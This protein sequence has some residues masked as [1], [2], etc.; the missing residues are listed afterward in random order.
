MLQPYCTPKHDVR[1][2]IYPKKQYVYKWHEQP[3][4]DIYMEDHHQPLA[5]P[6]LPLTGLMQLAATRPALPTTTC[7]PQAL[8]MQWIYM[9]GVHDKTQG[10]CKAKPTGCQEEKGLPYPAY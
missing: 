10:T 7:T 8:N 4:P 6:Q 1:V 2:A 3:L 5:T 9:A